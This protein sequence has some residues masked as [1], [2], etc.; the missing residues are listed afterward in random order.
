MWEGGIK[1]GYAIFI[2]LS[3]PTPNTM[4]HTG[5]SSYEIYDL[6]TVAALTIDHI[7]VHKTD[8]SG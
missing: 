3:A 8:L 6:S 4:Q 1:S 5:K 7:A 2:C